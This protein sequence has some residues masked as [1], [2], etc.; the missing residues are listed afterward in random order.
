MD[1]PVK[2]SKEDVRNQLSEL[3]YSNIE[4][5]KLEEFCQDLKRLI[6]YEEKKSNVDRKLDQLE[7]MELHLA[8]DKEN[9]DF[10]PPLDVILTLLTQL[11]SSFQVKFTISTYKR[12]SAFS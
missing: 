11:H 1:R 6:K 7:K 4:D 9:Q 10:C 5:S 3:G 2:F 12:W 8:E